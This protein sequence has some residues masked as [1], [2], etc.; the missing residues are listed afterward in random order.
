LAALMIQLGNAV[1]PGRG[2]RHGPFASQSEL[3][4]IV[5][6]AE[7]DHLIEADEREM[8]HSVF[9]LSGTFARNV[10]VPRTE[11]VWI[12]QDKSLRQAMSLALRSGFSRIPVIGTDADD[13][14]GVVYLRDLV[15]RAFEER[16]TWESARVSSTMRE[17]TLVPDSKPVDDLLREMQAARVHLAIAVDEYGGTAGL[18][19][20]EDI[21]EEIV[22]DIA[23]E[24]DR[25]ETPDLVD[26]GP[27]RWRVSARLPLADLA[28]VTGIDVTDDLESVETVAGLLAR[29]L[30]VVPIPGSSVEIDGCVLVAEELSGRRNQVGTILVQRRDTPGDTAR[31][32]TDKSQKGSHG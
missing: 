11:M 14:V 6:L 2:Y 31:E 29:R 15:R 16:D 3:R 32:P 13:I 17:A 5:D 7:A 22:G 26:L 30:G 19:T 24:Y 1:T 18:I 8:I 21:I 4:E 23:D 9:E 10:M 27:G 20:I 12:E 25:D 28:E